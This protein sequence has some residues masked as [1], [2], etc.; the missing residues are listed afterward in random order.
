MGELETMIPRFPS[1]E[2]G[3]SEE[4]YFCPILGEVCRKS[5]KMARDDEIS[6]LR[7][8]GLLCCSGRPLLRQRAPS[9]LQL[10]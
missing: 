1:A 2:V 3:S 6:Y 4:G 9:A 7:M 10:S 8:A 5:K